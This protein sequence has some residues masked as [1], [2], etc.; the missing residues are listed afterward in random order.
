M[1]S[2]ER[3]KHPRFTVSVPVEVHAEG[4]DT[5]IR[6]TTSDLSLGGCYIESMYPFPV[7]ATLDLR[8]QL[9]NTLLVEAKVVTSYP[10]VGNGMEFIRML[11]EDRAELRAFLESLAKKQELAAAGKK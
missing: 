4:S 6:C 7:G 8:L 3:R 5:P 10:Q 9:E 1:Y 2:P 11:P